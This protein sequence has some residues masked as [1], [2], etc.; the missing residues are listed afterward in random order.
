MEE[1]KIESSISAKVWQ[2]AADINHEG[3]Y[4][5]L[6]ATGSNAMW[7]GITRRVMKSTDPQTSNSYTTQHNYTKCRL[8]PCRTYQLQYCQG[9]QDKRP[10]VR[11]QLNQASKVSGMPASHHRWAN[12]VYWDS[13]MLI[14]IHGYLGLCRLSLHKYYWLP[15]GRPFL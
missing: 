14:R 8:Y 6:H 13:L 5:E 12:F 15:S 2:T 3:G 4:E 9:R 1:D 7:D 10:G 11:V